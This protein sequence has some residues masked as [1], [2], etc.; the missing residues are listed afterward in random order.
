MYGG[1]EDLLAVMLQMTAGEVLVEVAVLEV[2][3]NLEK[4]VRYWLRLNHTFEV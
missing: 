2:L 1:G 3:K 4:I